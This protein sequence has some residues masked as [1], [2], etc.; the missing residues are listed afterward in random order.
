MMVRLASFKVLPYSLGLGGGVVK[1]GVREFEGIVSKLEWFLGRDYVEVGVGKVIKCSA[2]SQA[3]L[4]ELRRRTGMMVFPISLP[5]MVF[6]EVYE[7]RVFVHTRLR[8][9]IH[10]DEVG[11]F[12]VSKNKRVLAHLKTPNSTPTHLIA[13]FRIRGRKGGHYQGLLITHTTTALDRI[14]AILAP[15]NT[16]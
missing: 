14:S 11:V 4:R 15:E 16:I 10:T 1:V 8:K 3:C 9:L 13:R 2:T 6:E 5:Y 7:L 12:L